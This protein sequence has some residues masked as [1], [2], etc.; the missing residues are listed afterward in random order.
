MAF[1]EAGFDLSFYMGVLNLS[2]STM[3]AVVAFAAAV[4]E[5]NSLR[6][7]AERRAIFSI[8]QLCCIYV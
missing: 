6:S 4:S 1:P 5:N 7:G 2:S 3:T 8:N